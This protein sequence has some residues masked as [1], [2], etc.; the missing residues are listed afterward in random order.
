[1]GPWTAL[2]PPTARSPSSWEREELLE[3]R[4]PVPSDQLNCHRLLLPSTRWSALP[5]SSPH[6]ETTC[7][8]LLCTQKAL[9]VSTSALS[10]SPHPL[11]VS[12]QLVPSSHTSSSQSRLTPLHW[13]CN[14]A[15]L[16]TVPWPSVCSASWVTS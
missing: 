6:S 2:L 4:S 15:T 13:P 5:L 14:T 9:M 12:P 1:M 16:S 3:P 10:H 7:T 8:W 11:E